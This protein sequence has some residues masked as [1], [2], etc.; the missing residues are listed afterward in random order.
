[1][2]RI[3]SF[4]SFTSHY[5]K[6][7]IKY[8]ETICGYC[9]KTI[10]KTT[11]HFNRANKLGMKLFCNHTCFGLNRRL[12]KSEEQKK[13]EKAIYDREYREL[14]KET[15]KKKKAIAFKK[16]YQKNPEKYRKERQRRM[17][18]HIEYCRSEKY[19]AYKKEYDL[20]YRSK[21]L[22][23]EYAECAIILYKIEHILTPY[24]IR[25]RWEKGCGNKTQNRKR[26]WK[27][28][29]RSISKMHSGIHSKG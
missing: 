20:K 11:G 5:S 8:I 15:L 4:R 27:N 28:L 2:F 24:K 9:G 22:Y 25:L 17:A 1:L 19:R 23:G 6:M 3:V 26:L 16:D 14:K 13:S 29:Q 21:K 7:G 10:E 12:N 18:A